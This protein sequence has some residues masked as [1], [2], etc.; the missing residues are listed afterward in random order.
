[1][2][3]GTGCKILHNTLCLSYGNKCTERVF[4]RLQTLLQ[5]VKAAC[6]AISGMG[7]A[8]ALLMYTPYM[9]SVVYD[10]YTIDV[11][12][13]PVSWWMYALNS[14]AALALYVF[15]W[16]AVGVALLLCVCAVYSLSY[17]Y[18]H[19]TQL[20]GMVFVITGLSGLSAWYVVDLFP[21]VVPGGLYGRTVLSVV[22][23]LFDPPLVTLCFVVILYVGSVLCCPGKGL[24]L[25]RSC[26]K[27]VV[28]L[29]RESIRPERLSE[30]KV[31]KEQVVYKTPLALFEKMAVSAPKMALTEEHRQ[32]ARTLQEKLEHF[33]IQGA[34]VG[35]HPGPVVTLYEYE[36]VRNVK[37]SK[38]I[39]LHSDLSMALK[40]TS[41]RILAPIP[42]REVVGF[43]VANEH[44]VTLLWSDKEL[45]AALKRSSARLPLLLGVTTECVPYITDLAGLPH[46]LVAGAT[47]SGK[48]V[49]IHG[50][51]LS[52]LCKKSP[53]ELKLV[54][55]DPKRLEFA[56]Y[57]D[58]PHL[59]V[60]IVTESARAVVVIRWLVTVM[61]ERYATLA[62]SGV[63]SIDEYTAC[64]G[65]KHMPY[66]VV[67]IDELAD[68][69]LVSGR[70][71]EEAI[72]RLAQ[73]ARAAGIHLVLATQ[74]PSVDVLTGLIKANIP[75]RCALKVTSQI[76]SRTIIDM[77][78]AEQLLGKGDL[79]FVDAKGGMS[80]LHAPYVSGDDSALVV[81]FLKKQRAPEYVT[82][83]VPAASGGIVDADDP[84]VSE[85]TVFVQSLNE[86]SISLVQRR[87]RIGYNRAARLV[88]ILESRGIVAAA[89]GGKM[90]KVVHEK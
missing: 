12:A 13:H 46:L 15:G 3:G 86:I 37:L 30:K 78:G 72:M 62:A 6:F 57:E 39:A 66:I 7:L 80:R 52:L 73:M 31:V 76:D 18:V 19:A 43:E 33:G 1:M 81:D 40:A 25:W 24:V 23:F 22:L 50:M 89:D 27:S 58:V 45:I 60:P 64:H 87:F 85:V 5:I 71:V 63:R 16:M 54:L 17:T 48:S 20:W 35:I 26:S 11:T 59:L 74:R 29:E 44:R 82:I 65:V 9:P 68:L 69:M 49:S 42:G 79:L 61:E 75:A 36:P 70:D 84:L 8:Y 47:G 51:L 2:R 55:I 34:V 67:V 28:P 88:E 32:Q 4:M 38:I 90:R 10:T 77:G 83:V 56:S 21:G 14:Y 53:D 41:L